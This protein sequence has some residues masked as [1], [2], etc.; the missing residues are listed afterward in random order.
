M[1]AASARSWRVI[2]WVGGIIEKKRKALKFH[3]TLAQ[4]GTPHPGE[5]HTA[6]T[7]TQSTGS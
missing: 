2:L 3:R 6:P 4:K 7:F 5:K 1:T